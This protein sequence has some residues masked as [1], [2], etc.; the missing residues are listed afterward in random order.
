VAEA[1][2]VP[3]P[4]DTV[5]RSPAS[6]A[7]TFSVDG[8]QLGEAGCGTDAECADGSATSPMSPAIVANGV[9]PVRMARTR[10]LFRGT[11]AAAA[12]RDGRKQAGERTRERR[13]NP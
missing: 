7:D 9:S 3:G 4:G 6:A 12:H 10:T 2:L 8:T 1:S 5:T 11:A 13:T